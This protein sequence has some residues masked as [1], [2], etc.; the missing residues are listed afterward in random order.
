MA[1]IHPCLFVLQRK[2]CFAVAMHKFLNDNSAR[3]KI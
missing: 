2:V 1:Q 3:G